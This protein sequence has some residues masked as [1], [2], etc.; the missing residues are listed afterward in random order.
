MEV[1]WLAPDNNRKGGDCSAE[2]LGEWPGGTQHRASR[3][4]ST[5]PQ[6]YLSPDWYPAWVPAVVGL[7]VRACLSTL[8]SILSTILSA[9][10][11]SSELQ[12]G[13]P[14]AGRFQGQAR[15]PPPA[16]PAVLFPASPFPLLNVLEVYVPT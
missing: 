16:Q 1:S 11:R 10:E 4:E 8:R 6:V 15:A 14:G 5:R 2:R 3:R 12:M 9:G 7:R 13:R